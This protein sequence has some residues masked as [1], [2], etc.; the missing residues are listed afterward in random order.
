M[1]V[2]LLVTILSMSTG[3][4]LFG[5]TNNRGVDVVYT[6]IPVPFCPSP[7]DIKIPSLLTPLLTPNST[8]GEVAVAYKHDLKVLRSV[9][10]QQQDVI[11]TYSSISKQY[12][13]ILDKAKSLQTDIKD[14]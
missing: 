8:D 14:K 3:C 1:R 11:N 13:T 2:F 5:S 7:A 4:S 12:D 6:T 10:D 9:V